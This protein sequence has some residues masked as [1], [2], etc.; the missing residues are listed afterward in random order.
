MQL[1]DEH[2]L[3][4]TPRVH[5]DRD[6]AER[7][8]DEDGQ[9]LFEVVIRVPMIMVMI[10]SMPMPVS[11]RIGDVVHRRASGV[12]GLFVLNHSGLGG[13]GRGE[14]F[15]ARIVNRVENQAVHQHLREAAS[16]QYQDELQPKDPCVHED[17]FQV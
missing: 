8:A 13:L 15:W 11:S 6:Q 14:L 16:D 17:Q 2:M 9:Q 1:R 7:S 5:K 12:G 4:S 10:V 3:E